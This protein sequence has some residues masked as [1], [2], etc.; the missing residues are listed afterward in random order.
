M[1]HSRAVRD[2]VLKQKKQKLRKKKKKKKA[3]RMSVL[4]GIVHALAISFIGIW[5]FVI[6]G[7]TER[8]WQ[9][10]RDLITG[11]N[12]SRP[13]K[14]QQQHVKPASNVRYSSLWLIALNFV[15]AVLFLVA[16]K[17]DKTKQIKTN[18]V[19]CNFR[20]VQYCYIFPFPVHWFSAVVLAV[21]VV[22]VAVGWLIS[23]FWFVC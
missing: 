3:H 15:V 23:C 9:L 5:T 6:F 20:N 16:S 2:A 7:F 4:T 21:F 17:L 14:N 12:V 11:V 13:A 18:F 1:N 10:W 22:V 8:N 19:T